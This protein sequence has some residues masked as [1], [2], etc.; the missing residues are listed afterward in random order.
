MTTVDVERVGPVFPG[1]TTRGDHAMLA[2]MVTR[3]PM[4]TIRLRQ[5]AESLGFRLNGFVFVRGQWKAFLKSYN[6]L[7]QG[8]SN[9]PTP[10]RREGARKVKTQSTP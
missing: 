2:A 6:H 1:R 7:P 9:P 3:Q 4:Y 10:A 8:H 5:P